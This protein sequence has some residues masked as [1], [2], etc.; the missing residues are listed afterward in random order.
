[1][2]MNSASIKGI[3]GTKNSAAGIERLCRSICPE[4]IAYM[5]I[6]EQADNLRADEVEETYQELD[7]RVDCRWPMDETCGTDFQYRG[8]KKE[9]KI[10]DS[11][12]RH[13]PAPK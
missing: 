8:I 1:M 5:R 11:Q 7:Q 4:L 9:N 12:R 10:R 2:K 6:L 13:N 3:K